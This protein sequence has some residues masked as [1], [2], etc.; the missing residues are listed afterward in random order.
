MAAITLKAIPASLHRKLKARARHNRRSLNQEV[1]ATLEAAIAPPA[2]VDAEARIRETVKFRNSL[3][4]RTTPQEI[5]E[6]KREG[7]A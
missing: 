4:I 2:L 7:R 1:L 3:K 6:F 5:D